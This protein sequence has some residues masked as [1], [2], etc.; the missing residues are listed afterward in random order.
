MP[1][2]PLTHRS[3]SVE[4]AANLRYEDGSGQLIYKNEY[5]SK[6]QGPIGTVRIEQLQSEAIQNLV[7]S[8]TSD[9]SLSK[10]L[11]AGTTAK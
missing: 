8:I 2:G 10:S 1:A 6:G 7:E 3:W 9:E 11:K 4:F 5:Q